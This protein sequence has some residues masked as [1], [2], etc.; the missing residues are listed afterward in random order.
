MDATGISSVE[1]YFDIDHLLKFYGTASSVTATTTT[2]P[3]NTNPNKGDQIYVEEGT[4]AGQLVLITSVSDQTA[5]HEAWPRT[6]ISASASTIILIPGS[7][8]LA[9][10]GINSDA[11]VSTRSSHT[12]HYRDK[13]NNSSGRWNCR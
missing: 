6:N 3:A 5:T 13:F 8:T 1:A 10:G 11:Q 9:D 7:V 4:G 2:F 12:E